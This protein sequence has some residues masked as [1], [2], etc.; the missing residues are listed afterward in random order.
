MSQAVPVTILISALLLRSELLH[1]LPG[2]AHYHLC[3]PGQEVSG[4]WGDDG[5]TTH[6]RRVSG[7]FVIRF[8][9]DYTS[10][11]IVRRGIG[12]TI[13]NNRNMYTFIGA[14]ALC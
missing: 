14:S 4:K 11:C 12:L 3:T 6:K 1:P 2:S 8:T 10:Q 13:I 9:G 5:G 7:A